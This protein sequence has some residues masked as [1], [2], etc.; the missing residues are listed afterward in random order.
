MH[1]E[2]PIDDAELVWPAATENPASPLGDPVQPAQEEGVQGG[3]CRDASVDDEVRIVC[4]NCFAMQAT[5][6][7]ELKR[8]MQTRLTW[9]TLRAPHRE[10]LEIITHRMAAIMNGGSM[11][12]EHWRAIADYAS[13]VQRWLE[14]AS[15]HCPACKSSSGPG[16]RRD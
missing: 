11:E 16:N 15:E 8:V 14:I 4:T 2:T 7:Q 3:L 1:N 12:P 6:A 10:A 5:I 13:A 9:Q